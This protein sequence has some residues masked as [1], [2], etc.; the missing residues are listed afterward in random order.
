MA[1]GAKYVGEWKNGLLHGQGTYTFATGERHSGQFVAGSL[2]GIGTLVSAHGDKYVGEIKNSRPHGRGTNTFVEGDKYIGEH[3]DGK[4]DGLG[5]YL[6][7]DGSNYVGETKNNHRHGSGI[8]TFADGKKQEGIWENDKFIRMS[9]VNLPDNLITEKNRLT[10]PTDRSKEDGKRNNDMASSRKNINLQLTN[11]QP[12]NSGEF[13]INIQANTELAS[14]TIDGN[15]L[16]GS[17]DGKYIVKR[18]ALVGKITEISIIAKDVYGNTGTGKISVFRQ[19]GSSNQFKYAELSPSVIKQ[20][21]AKDAI[22]IIIGIA[23]YKKLPKADYANDDARVFYDYA[24]RG[25]GIKAENIKLL[26]DADAD[27]AE[28]IKAFKNWL[29][30]RVKSTTDIYVYYSGHGLPSADGQNLYLLPQ[31]ADRDLIEDTAISQSRI[32]TAI[33]ATKPKSVTIFI[34]SCYSG[35][36]R[37]G[38]TLLASARPISLKSN[39]QIFPSDFTVFTASTAD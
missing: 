14:L 37:T 31:Q 39:T 20:Q 4:P 21:S 24:I 33:Q 7:R 38:Q 11:T 16:G 36:G 15:E 19:A 1:D 32:N 23:D 3:K 12:N 34:D 28:I 2:N 30:P 22:A 18:V 29:P 27:Q 25:L 13:V 9:K 17:K 8:M 5:I 10:S 26:V 6:S 35:A